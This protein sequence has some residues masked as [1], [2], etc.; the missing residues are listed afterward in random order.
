MITRKQSDTGEF[1]LDSRLDRKPVKS[2]V[3]QRSDAASS[4]VVRRISMISI[5]PDLLEF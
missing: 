5:V 1:V 3:K 4:V 2:G